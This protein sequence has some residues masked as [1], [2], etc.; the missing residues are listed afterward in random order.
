VS[1]DV[2]RGELNW[3]WKFAA[4]GGIS[5]LFCLPLPVWAREKAAPLPVPP[6]IVLEGGRRLSFERSFSSEKDV[7]KK[8]GLFGKL[9]N[10]VAGEPDMHYL[11]RPYSIAIDSTGRAIITDPGA[12]GIHIFDFPQKKYK[13]IERRESRN[14]PM[15]SPQ[16]VAVD[17]DDNFYVTDSVAGKIFVFRR[18]GKFLQ[19]I[20]SLKGG[21][22]YF[23]RPTGIAVDSAAQRI[24]VTDTLRDQI[25][26]LDMQGNVLEKI[27]KKGGDRGE[28]RLPTELKLKGRELVVVDAMNLRV[29]ML[30]RNGTFLHSIGPEEKQRGPFQRP[31]AVAVDSEGHIYVVEALRNTVQVHDS[32]GQLLYYFGKRGIGLGDFQLPTGLFIDS[33]DRI[34]VVD[35]YNRRV[36]VFHYFGH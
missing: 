6:D 3:A 26:V 24:Y 4:I 11:V 33:R 14:D 27:G 31:K 28:F 34:Y 7:R 29:Q 25:F 12:E 36:Q 8:P 16:C 10:F 21:E 22:G 30:D 15:Q 13:F 5:L 19:A 32:N 1:F 23:K 18:D 35:S 20:G 9:L 17:A 2:R